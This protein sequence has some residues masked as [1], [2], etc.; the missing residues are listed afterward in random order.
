L[1]YES[2]GKGKVF[3]YSLQSVDPELIRG[4][5]SQ[6]TG[7]FLSHHG[8]MLPLFF[9]RPVSLLLKHSPDGTTT[10]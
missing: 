5:G 3:P 10:N 9:A 8:G 6:P 1:Y 4:T 2:K 7:D